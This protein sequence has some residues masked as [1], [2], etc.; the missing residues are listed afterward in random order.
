MREGEVTNVELAELFRT[1]GVTCEAYGEWLVFPQK[2]MRAQARIFDP[3]VTETIQLDVRLE[4]WPGWFLVESFAGLGQDRAASIANAFEAFALASLPVLLSA[5]LLPHPLVEVNREEWLINGRP[6]ILTLGKLLQRGADAD[7]LWFAEFEEIIKASA[8]TE[9]THWIR[10]YYA[11]HNR[12]PMSYEA[13]LDNEPWPEIQRAMER[14]DWWTG[15]GFHSTRLFLVV[16]GGVGV[17]QACS[18]ISRRNTP[19]RI[20]SR[21]E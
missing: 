18:V 13:L 11:Q 20:S 12:K 7:P 17:G 5:F 2:E 15:D 6:R 1:H 19:P 21:W 10:L 4:L 16:Q 14:F 9:G 3:P 8:L